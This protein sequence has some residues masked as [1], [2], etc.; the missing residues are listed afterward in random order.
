MDSYNIITL[1]SL[2]ITV[3]AFF[4]RIERRLTRLETLIKIILDNYCKE[5]EE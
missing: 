3:G 2:T 5:K 4:L 1:A